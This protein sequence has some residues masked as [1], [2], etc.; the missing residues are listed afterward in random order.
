M[1]TRLTD[2]ERAGLAQTLPAWTLVEGRDAIARAFQFRDFSEAWGFM[3]RVALLAESQNHHPEW[4]NVWNRV[5][6]NFQRVP[7]DR[8]AMTCWRGQSMRCWPDGGQLPGRAL[9]IRRAAGRVPAARG[10][11]C[12]GG[13]NG[14]RAGYPG[15]APRWLLRLHRGEVGTARLSD[16]SKW[17]DYREFA[18]ELFFAVDV[19]F[20][21]SLP[22]ETGLIV[23]A[24]L[25]QN[26]CARLPRILAGARRRSLLHR[27]TVGGG[28][29]GDTGDPAVADIRAALRAV[30]GSLRMNTSGIDHGARLHGPGWPGRQSLRCRC[31]EPDPVG[32]TRSDDTAT[33]PPRLPPAT[34]RH[35]R[36]SRSHPALRGDRRR[37]PPHRRS[38]PRALN[39]PSS[40]STGGRRERPSPGDVRV[41]RRARVRFRLAQ[42]R[43]GRTMAHCARGRRDRAI[44]VTRAVRMQRPGKLH[45]S[46]V[47]RPGRY[48]LSRAREQSRCAAQ[49]LVGRAT[50]NIWRSNPPLADRFDRNVS[51]KYLL[52]AA[53]G[54]QVAARP[55]TRS[56]SGTGSAW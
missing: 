51:P 20:P 50:S 19:D 8:P 27:C 28:A 15:A 40:R 5:R 4:S 12:T 1:A 31:P 55:R 29:S 9:A 33:E 44:G 24:G 52:G 39:L 30:H 49:T 13:A 26:C 41:Q 46:G 18:D 23:A 6:S 14:R 25:R 7:A 32:A 2:A 47:H 38:I 10:R 54:F 22:I 48:R 16:R 35:T 21:A 43:R 42:S 11:R 37:H 36:A 17:Q 56:E 3:N 45:R 53:G 34:T